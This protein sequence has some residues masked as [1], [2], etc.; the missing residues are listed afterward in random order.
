MRVPIISEFFNS[1]TNRPFE[2][3]LMCAK[4]LLTTEE[5]Y[6]IERIF[7]RLV[8]LNITEPIFEYAVCMTCAK[9]FKEKLSAASQQSV[10]LYYRSKFESLTIDL[11]TAPAERL[12]H[13]LFTAKPII[14]CSEFSY[15][16][17][18]SGSNMMISIFPY[19]VSDSAMDEISALL[20]Q[21]TLDELDD[22]KGKYFGGP[23]ELAEFINPKRLVL[24]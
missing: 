21:E 7:R 16:A 23:P 9:Q 10:E 6:F 1:E 2:S 3:C 22:F 17:H 20:S 13:C 8:T 12:T 4:Q 14:D 5:D 18:C 19:A 15:H 24:L 11:S